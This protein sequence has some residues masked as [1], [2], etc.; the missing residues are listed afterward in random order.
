MIN[1]IKNELIQ[2]FRRRAAGSVK[3]AQLVKVE[4]WINNWF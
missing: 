3:E 2:N 4:T 1:K